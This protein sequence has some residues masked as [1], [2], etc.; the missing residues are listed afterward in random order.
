M[1][2]TLLTLAVFPRSR[3]CILL[4]NGWEPISAG[5]RAKLAEVVFSGEAV[6]TYKNRRDSVSK[7][8]TAGFSVQQVFKG[9]EIVHKVVGG[10]LDKNELA[11]EY[12][13]VTNF[14]DRSMCYA[15]VK[16]GQRYTGC[17]FFS[18]S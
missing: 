4:L 14:G 15:D 18:I 3:A 11:E 12:Y 13:N 10:S 8:Y 16:E 2:L 6:K 9:Q 7:T 1:I 5:D 17:C